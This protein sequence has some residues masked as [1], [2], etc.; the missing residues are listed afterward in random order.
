M[1]RILYSGGYDSLAVLLKYLETNSIDSVELVYISLEN[2]EYKTFME[3]EAIKKQLKIIETLFTDS[4]NLKQTFFDIKH[5]AHK[6]YFNDYCG[7]IQQP[8]FIHTLLLSSDSNIEEIQMGL[9]EQK[10]GYITKISEKYD[11]N[12]YDILNN[13]IISDYKLR[14]IDLNNI[15]KFKFPLYDLNMNK[16]DVLKYI[17]NHPLGEE[18]YPYAFTC[19]SIEGE[20][21]I[22]KGICIKEENSDTVCDKCKEISLAESNLLNNSNFEKKEL[23]RKLIMNRGINLIKNNKKYIDID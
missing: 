1:N 9:M 17:L 4:S 14:G 16:E 10:G 19:E 2:N 12:I 23:L 5:I 7:F 15:P 8:L 20:Y 18:L 22:Q 13:A 6:S 11:E 3:K 21:S